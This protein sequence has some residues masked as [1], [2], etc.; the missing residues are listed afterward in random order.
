MEAI[1]ALRRQIRKL[2]FVVSKIPN[3][4]LL[5]VLQIEVRIVYNTFIVIKV[6]EIY[7]S[8]ASLLIYR[9]ICKT[10]LPREKIQ[11]KK[12]NFS[13]TFKI[14]NHLPFETFHSCG[15]DLLVNL[16]NKPSLSFLYKIRKTFNR[17]LL[18]LVRWF[19]HWFYEVLPS[20]IY[21]TDDRSFDFGTKLRS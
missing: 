6:W 20:S 4:V 17:I 8:A 18:Y 19:G 12:Q 11:L 7:H 15:K 21:R 13:K 3:F 2:F 5:M 16:K 9:Y 14:N 1:E 10:L